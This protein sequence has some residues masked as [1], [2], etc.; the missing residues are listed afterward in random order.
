MVRWQDAIG[1]LTHG[2]PGLHAGSVGNNGFALGPPH[3][4]DEEWRGVY[5]PQQLLMELVR[6]PNYST[7]QGD[8]W[9]FHCGGIM[10]YLGEWTI[11]DF[12][13]ARPADP[14]GLFAEIIA[15]S[16]FWERE[17]ELLGSDS[18]NCYVHGCQRCGALRAYC[19]MD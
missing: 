7:W 2:V 18:C 9:F 1:G 11:D 17:W 14:R 15:P 3:A 13:R 10:C 5:V 19:D 6:T 16:R 8:T 4:G 12:D